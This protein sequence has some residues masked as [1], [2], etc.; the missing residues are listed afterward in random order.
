[1]L[2]VVVPIFRECEHLKLFLQRWLH[3]EGEVCVYV[4][5]ASHGDESTEYIKS[6]NTCRVVEVPGHS[7]S[8][9]AESVSSG[10]DAFLSDALNPND[11]VAITNVDVLPDIQTVLNLMNYNAYHGPVVAVCKSNGI[12]LSLGIQVRSWM[13]SINTH[14]YRGQIFEDISWSNKVFDYAPTRLFVLSKADL[15]KSGGPNYQAL[16]HYCSDYEFTGRVSRSCGGIGL[17][18]RLCCEVDVENTGYKATVDSGL[19]SRFL[20]GFNMK[21]VYCYRY[22]FRYVILSYPWW[23][24]PTGLLTHFAKISYGVVRGID[25]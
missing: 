1:M 23:A 7:G 13:F 11:V 24:I 21:C 10:L 14:P 18:H 15:E 9:W 22:R 8:F 3:H 25:V 20:L 16:P 12:A 2:Y 19:F 17:D 6:L 5:N 4:C